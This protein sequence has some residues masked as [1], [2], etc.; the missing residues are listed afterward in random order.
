[1]IRAVG[2]GGNVTGLRFYRMAYLPC[3]AM[4]ELGLRELP[5]KLEFST[6]YGL[7]STI[8]LWEVAWNSTRYQV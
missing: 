7:T 5:V 8:L 6:L 4:R 2:P 1:M 3:H